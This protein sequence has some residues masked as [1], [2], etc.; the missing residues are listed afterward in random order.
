M[1][2]P[3]SIPP[4]RSTQVDKQPPRPRL[5]NDSRRNSHNSDEGKTAPLP[6]F[7]PTPPLPPVI[8]LKGDEKDKVAVCIL[9]EREREIQEKEKI[10]EIEESNGWRFTSDTAG[11]MYLKIQEK[12]TSTFI[13]CNNF[14][15]D[16]KK[17][18]RSDPRADLRVD[19]KKKGAPAPGLSIVLTPENKAQHLKRLYALL[20]SKNRYAQYWTI[21]DIPSEWLKIDNEALCSEKDQVVIFED[22]EKKKRALEKSKPGGK[23]EFGKHKE[24]HRLSINDVKITSDDRQ[25]TGHQGPVYR[26]GVEGMIATEM[27]RSSRENLDRRAHEERRV[28][29]DELEGERMISEN[30]P[31]IHDT[32]VDKKIKNTQQAPISGVGREQ[33]VVEK[34]RGNTRTEIDERTKEGLR[35]SGN[36]VAKARTAIAENLKHNGKKGI[37]GK[38]KGERQVLG[39]EIAKEKLVHGDRPRVG[40]PEANGRLRNTR[41]APMNGTEKEQTLVD[42]PRAG[43]KIKDD[44]NSN[45]NNVLPDKRH[46][47]AAIDEIGDKKTVAIERSRNGTAETNKGSKDDSVLPKKRHGSDTI[48]EAGNIGAMAVEKSGNG[49]AET[50]SRPKDRSLPSKKRHGNQ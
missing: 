10:Q 37:D 27:R 35:V 4:S 3:T 21:E 24:R 48:D 49:K 17:A 15:R 38:S 19:S 41:R 26:F 11:K 9:K 18:I 43:S 13:E 47:S 31:R 50:D 39:D 20:T 44:V 1:S 14:A 25:R 5:E 29:E 22:V 6:S 46:G 42:K 16:C 2:P 32:K 34:P 45:E 12:D 30:R 33:I 28:L 7:Y 40:N 36:E 8:L 23:V